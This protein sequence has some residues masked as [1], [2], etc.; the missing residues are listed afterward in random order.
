MGHYI[1]KHS[2]CHILPDTLIKS[3]LFLNK[4]P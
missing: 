1:E 2:R 4:L 3:N